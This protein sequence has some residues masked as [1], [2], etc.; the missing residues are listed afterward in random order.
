[1]YVTAGPGGSSSTSISLLEFSTPD[2]VVSHPENT[3]Y[4]FTTYVVVTVLT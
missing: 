2:L 4:F 1:M 3:R